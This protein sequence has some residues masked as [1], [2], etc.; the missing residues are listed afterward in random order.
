MDGF[1]GEGLFILA[2][3]V[4]AFVN[5]L[6]NT[7]KARAAR[8]ETERRR[9]RGELPPTETADEEG[10]WPE[11]DTAPDI[12]V[13]GGADANQEIRDF[14]AA[15]SGEAPPQPEPVPVVEAPLLQREPAPRWETPP[16][17]EPELSAAERRALDNIQEFPLSPDAS[18]Q[19]RP[20]HPIVDMLRSSVGARNAIILAEVL[21]KPKALAEGDGLL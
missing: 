8:R 10:S 11:P 16:P 12:Y 20:V 1:D 13:P 3:V 6:S 14:F 17:I 19:R 9:A 4:I 18:R 2:A 21:G 7:L 15:L 5:W